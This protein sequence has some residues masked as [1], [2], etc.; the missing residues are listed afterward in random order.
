MAQPDG[1]V[2]AGPEAGPQESGGSQQ[3]R[4][5][6]QGAEIQPGGLETQQW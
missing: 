4:E 3:I 2:A 6:W 5:T 1:G